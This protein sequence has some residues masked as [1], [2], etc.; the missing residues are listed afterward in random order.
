[1]ATT[2]WTGGASTTA[3]EWKGTVTTFADNDVYKL[4]LTREDQSTVDIVNYTVSGAA[5]AAVVATTIANEWN[6]N[7]DIDAANITATT[8][9][10]QVILTAETGGIPFYVTASASGGSAAWSGTG[11]T[12]SNSGPHDWN[13]AGN[14]SGGSVPVDADKVQIVRNSNGGSYGVK[15]GL[16]QSAIQLK[17]LRVSKSFKESA[18]NPE[19]TFPLII[20]VNDTGAS[21]TPALVLQGTGRAQMFNGDINMVIVKATG[22][23]SDAV[24]LEGDIDNLFIMGPNVVGTITLA[25]NSVLDNVV[26][27]DAPNARLEI[28]SNVTSFDT[29]RMNSGYVIN[30]SSVTNVVTTN[31]TYIQD[32]GSIGTWDNHGGTHQYNSDDNITTAINNYSGIIDMTRNTGD[33]VTILT[34][35]GYGGFVDTRTGLANITYTSGPFDYFGNVFAFDPGTG[36]PTLI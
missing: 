23:G 12:T 15:Y 22:R 8:N 26:V 24:Y 10:A 25:N 7:G 3:Q 6:N 1:M 2:Q 5:S 13:T 14:F 19:R 29:I 20:D 33:A 21:N 32:D 34:A 4:T 30:N 9:S 16:D 17:S 18:G 36:A 35:F 28:G 11:N 31:G 27:M